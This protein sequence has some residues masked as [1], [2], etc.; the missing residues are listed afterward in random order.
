MKAEQGMKSF[1]RDSWSREGLAHP[2][3]RLWLSS[4]PVDWVGLGGLGPTFRAERDQVQR[5]ESRPAVSSPGCDPTSSLPPSSCHCPTSR[6]SFEP[7]RVSPKHF[8]MA[9]LLC[10][11]DGSIVVQRELQR[12]GANARVTRL[13]KWTCP[14]F[15]P[16]SEAR[17][18]FARLMHSRSI[19]ER[20]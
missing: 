2:G 14:V 4:G 8:H 20:P 1:L 5:R 13:L 3:L 10:T 7:S 11:L 18:E 6:P 16:L 12:S 19:P 9:L 17:L 15:F